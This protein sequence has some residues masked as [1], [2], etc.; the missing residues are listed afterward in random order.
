MSVKLSGLTETTSF[1]DTDIFHL[2]TIGGIDK[3]INGG[4]LISN[5]EL[6]SDAGRVQAFIMKNKIGWLW[7][8]GAQINKLTNPEYT[9]L[10]GLLKLEAGGDPTHPYYNA[11]AD[12][13]VL[14]NLKGAVI[15]GVDTVANRDKDGVR[16]SGGYQADDNKTHSHNNVIREPATTYYASKIFGTSNEAA[17]GNNIDTYTGNT[18][19]VEATMKN[20]ALYYLIKY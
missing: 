4:D 17:L 19:A 18:G 3:K 1:I 9:N 6:V 12:I 5:I 7:C 16:K 14:P 20:I 11:S 15:R 10:V 8:D 2:R 13:A